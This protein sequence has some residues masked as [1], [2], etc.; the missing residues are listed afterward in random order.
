MI[1]AMKSETHP[2][3]E[4]Y[5]AAKFVSKLGCF[6]GSSAEPEDLWPNLDFLEVDIN[7]HIDRDA[8]LAAW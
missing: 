2:S 3:E 5:I 6:S 1:T 7:P 8:P 4:T